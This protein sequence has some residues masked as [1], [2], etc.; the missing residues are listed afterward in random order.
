[1]ITLLTNGEK[2]MIKGL[3]ALTVFGV[4]VV[5]LIMVAEGAGL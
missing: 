5:A 3:L 2:T 4:F 1:M